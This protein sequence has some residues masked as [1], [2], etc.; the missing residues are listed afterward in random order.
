M[1]SGWNIP[2]NITVARKLKNG[3]ESSVRY[4]PPRNGLVSYL[5]YA[6][7]SSTYSRF[8]ISEA[9]PFSMELDEDEEI[10]EVRF[11]GRYES[12][13]M[14]RI[15]TGLQFITQKDGK[16]KSYNFGNFNSNQL[17][18]ISKRPSTDYEYGYMS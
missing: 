5:Q 10:T 15:I 9:T 4:S 2:T 8:H 13:V 18:L 7:T 1:L 16:S 17:Q 3:T 11:F 14:L 6:H 12:G